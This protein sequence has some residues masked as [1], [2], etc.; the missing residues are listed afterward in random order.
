MHPEDPKFAS[1]IKAGTFQA[2]VTPDDILTLEE[3]ATML[4]KCVTP[5]DK[6]MFQSLYESAA[7]P[8]EFLSLMKS[9]VSFE[10]DSA[11]FHIRKGKT[12]HPRDI[13]LVQDSH[14][15]LRN[16]IFNEHP[17]RDEKDFP[18]WVDMSRNSK[19][20]P[21]QQLGLRRFMER[22]SKAAGIS[23]R[24]TPYTLRHTRLT[25]LARENAS[26]ALLS[27]IAGWRPGSRM[28]SV[29][30]HLSKRDQKPALQKLLGIAKEDPEPKNDPRPKVCASCKTVNPSDARICSVCKMALDTKTAV[31]MITQRTNTIEM[32]VK[33]LKAQRKILDQIQKETRR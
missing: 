26:E 16:W 10:S 4:S 21:L 14:P 1:W 11:N 15:L 22:I 31:D 18:L 23:K 2:T 29:Y 32:L 7:R 5:R 24:V 30:I 25:D 33:E 12:G 20:E 8:M 3:R 9:D 19:H 6:T 13:T 28:P 27:L 17:L